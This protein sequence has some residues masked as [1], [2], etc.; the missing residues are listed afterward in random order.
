MIA[1]DG[2]L[3]P[4]DAATAETLL[5]LV[6]SVPS[7]KAEPIWLYNITPHHFFNTSTMRTA[8]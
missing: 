6:Q 8:S 4:T 3:R 5:H 2:K 7:P 1:A